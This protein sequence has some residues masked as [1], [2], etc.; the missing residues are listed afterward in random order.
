MNISTDTIQM[1]NHQLSVPD[2]VT[3]P[4]IPGDGIGPEVT[5]AM[6]SVVTA[7]L[8]EVYG[9]KRQIIWKEVLAGE[10]AFRQTEEWLPQETLYDFSHYMVGIKGP[11]STPVGEGIRS[12]NVA[13]RKDLDLYVCLRPVRY[14]KGIS[15]PVI[16]PEK[17]DVTIFRE[18]TEDV[19]TG[20]EF[21][22]DSPETSAL[23]QWLQE[24]Y[25]QS[26]GKIRFPQTVGI[27][28]KPISQQGSQR[29]LRAAIEFTIENK[30]PSITLVHKGNI[31]KFTEG[32]FRKWGYDLAES[33]Y[34]DFIYTSKQFDSTRKTFGLSV[35]REEKETALLTGKIW[36]NDVIVDA[37]FQNLLLYPE[38][39]SVIATTNLNGDYLS[40][41]LAAQVGGIGI[42]P[43][44]N[45]NYQT[46]IAIF[47]ATHGTAPDISGKNIANPS[48][49][50]LSS[51]MMLQY[52]G[53]QE[54]ADLI[55]SAVEMTIRNGQLTPDLAQF[56]KNATIVGTQEF[57]NAIIS[58]F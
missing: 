11:L 57:A 1:I 23:L 9:N 46:G 20:I 36:M 58:N 48:S 14:F 21:E 54:A 35:A 53:W 52:I 29:L 37:A 31:M 3:I 28:I 34:K 10:K 38:N 47:E 55:T 33:E 5:Q 41:A 16:N 8:T 42:A 50:I 44:A 26:F 32:A 18:N 22:A 15:A 4:F 51:V 27:G 2:L 30:K 24:N 13:L 25:P 43:G 17:I 56:V 12:L 7:A 6:Q 49:L 45:I 40:D 39:F 19:Y